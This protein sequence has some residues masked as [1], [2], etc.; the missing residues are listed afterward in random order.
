M[1]EVDSS[2]AG[3]ATIFF[4]PATCRTHENVDPEAFSEAYLIVVRK[5][6]S[7]IVRDE[8]V[9]LDE[10]LLLLLGCGLSFRPTRIEES[11]RK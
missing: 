1:I 10:P 2:N 8:R 5:Y 9:V 4:V 7:W 3:D 6:P 11:P